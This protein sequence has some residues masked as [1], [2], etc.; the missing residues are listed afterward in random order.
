MKRLIK[1]KVKSEKWRRSN[2][3]YIEEKKTKQNK[4]NMSICKE[5]MYVLDD[6]DSQCM[7]D[8]MYIYYMNIKYIIINFNTTQASY[9]N[10][11]ICI[12]WSFMWCDVGHNSKSK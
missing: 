1:N 11:T 3:D 8:G 9:F 12:M 7:L 6:E 2:R 5:T 4:Q 10:Y